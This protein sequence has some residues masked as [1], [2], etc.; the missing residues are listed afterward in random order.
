MG[1]SADETADR[2]TGRPT[3]ERPRRER[4]FEA[5]PVVTLGGPR[6]I[7]SD[8]LCASTRLKFLACLV[9]PLAATPLHAAEEWFLLARHG[10][11]AKVSVLKR[12]IPDL[13]AIND[14]KAFATLMRK[15]GY[16]VTITRNPLPKGEAYEVLVPEKELSLLFVTK[17]LCSGSDTR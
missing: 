16:K 1:P 14:P 13:G 15:K 4:R 9:A 12:K 2:D 6:S 11:C 17:E 10:E 8:M 3:S 5:E 7:H